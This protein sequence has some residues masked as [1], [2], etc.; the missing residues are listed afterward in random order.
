MPNRL[1]GK[2]QALKP[3]QI[4]AT[5]VLAFFLAAGDVVEIIPAFEPYLDNPLFIYFHY[6]HGGQAI[7]VALFAA[8]LVSPLLGW[9]F[10]AVFS[11]AHLPYFYLTF[12]ANFHEH[13]TMVFEVMVGAACVGVAGRL[14]GALRGAKKAA[15]QMEHLAGHDA[16]TGLANRSLFAEQTHQAMAAARRD[17]TRLA[18][19]FIDLDGFK[20]INDNLGHLVG[21]EVLI[22]IARRLQSGAREGD[23]VARLGGDEFALVVR[24]LSSVDDS[25]WFVKR[26][27]EQFYQPI[28][29]DSHEI[30]ISLSIGIA[31]YPSSI[32]TY[33]LSDSAQL[34]SHADTAM[35]RAK[36]LGRSN[37]EF[38]D[39]S[40]SEEITNRLVLVNDLHQAMALD[41]LTLLYQPQVDMRTGRIV[42][43][44]ALLR[45]NHPEKGLLSPGAFLAAAET[46]G[47][48]AQIDNWVIETAC[49]QNLAWQRLDLPPVRVAVNLSPLQ[50]RRQPIVEIVAKALEE[51]GLNPHHLDLELTENVLMEDLKDAAGELRRLQELGV[52]V[53]VDDFGT[54]YS[55][56]S[57]LQQFKVDRLKIDRSF[58]QDIHLGGDSRTICEAVIKLGHSLGAKVLAEGIEMREEFNYLL[59]LDCDE[60]QGYYH[61]KP[62]PADIFA[63]L[64]RED[65]KS[66]TQ[67]QSDLQAKL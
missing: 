43:A 63:R 58:V 39:R 31:P 64:L 17:Q 28:H 11:L 59:A 13:L 10:L 29:I 45:W 49:A 12:P 62:V 61:S 35:Y 4:F 14:Q 55:S 20:D 19:L 27:I 47:L 26:V 25:A 51:T 21:D 60:S 52:T 6:A 5:T 56:L 16:L 1:A 36:S 7:G 67:S 41:Q 2:I 37:F 53:S 33:Q 15:K 18:V 9:F 66:M 50:L 8:L 34:L 42:G 32:D 23:L 3:L 40:M 57:L 46:S 30:H 48:M 24:D 22:D 38:Y 44:E 65:A 54:G